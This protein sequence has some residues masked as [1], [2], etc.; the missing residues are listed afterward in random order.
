MSKKPYLLLLVASLFSQNIDGEFS[1][2]EISFLMKNMS[3]NFDGQTERLWI[4][5]L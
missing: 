2:G 3:Q 5:P 1:F 4:F